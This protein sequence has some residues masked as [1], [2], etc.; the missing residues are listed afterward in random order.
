MME[1]KETSVN[2]KLTFNIQDK[3]YFHSQL[4]I[5]LEATNEKTLLARAIHTILN[6]TI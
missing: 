2:G 4:Y 1:K 5:N 6:S 3:A